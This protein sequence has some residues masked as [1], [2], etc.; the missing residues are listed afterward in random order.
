MKIRAHRR[1]VLLHGIQGQELVLYVNAI[2]GELLVQLGIY[3]GF[4][5]PVAYGSGRRCFLQLPSNS[6][7]TFF[8]STRCMASS[9]VARSSGIDIQLHHKTDKSK[10]HPNHHASDT[11]PPSQDWRPSKKNRQQQ[12]RVQSKINGAAS[13]PNKK[14][15]EYKSDCTHK[16]SNQNPVKEHK[17]LAPG[18][19]NIARK[20]CKY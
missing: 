7:C 9:P 12:T 5:N 3:T 2:E 20:A 6:E 10:N 13:Q 11:N 16:R 8:V 17:N 1:E 4:L 19:Q 14:R 18:G 15:P